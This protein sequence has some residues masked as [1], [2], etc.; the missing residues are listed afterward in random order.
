MLR[1]EAIERDIYLIRGHRVMFD[2]NLAAL[3]G[4]A[5]RSLN[6]AVKRNRERFPNDFMFQLNKEE[7][8]DWKSQFVMSN[9]DK[10]GLRRP[11]YV[12]TEHGILMLSSVL[13]SPRAIEVNI[14]IMRIFIRIREMIITHKDF[15]L[16]LEKLECAVEK[17]ESHIHTIFEV[18]QQ[19][20][21]AENKPKR[22]IGFIK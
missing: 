12:F 18:I 2:R 4:V 1:G 20:T 16:R 21:A 11:P 13:N 3:Y 8:K 7:F 10:M 9:S 6:Q 22:R 19:L 5:T 15:A 14:A 17:Q